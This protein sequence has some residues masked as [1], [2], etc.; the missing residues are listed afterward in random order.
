MFGCVKVD[1]ATVVAVRCKGVKVFNEA[2]ITRFHV[3]SCLMS[4]TLSLSS[5]TLFCVGVPRDCLTNGRLVSYTAKSLQGH[6]NYETFRWLSVN[7]SRDIGCCSV[8][9]VMLFS[10]VYVGGE[11]GSGLSYSLIGAGFACN[12]CCTVQ[13]SWVGY[14]CLM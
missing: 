12:C 3:F 1:S 2:E 4:V 5:K 6:L 7:T 9:V 13:R 11:G 14:L 8:A 10:L